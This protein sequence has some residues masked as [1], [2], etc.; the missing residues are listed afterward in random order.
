M[1]QS[2]YLAKDHILEQMQTVAQ[3]GYWYCELESTE[4][5]QKNLDQG[6]FVS[7]TVKRIFDA[8]ND[9]N[10]TLN[11]VKNLLSEAEYAS[12]IKLLTEAVC[13][14][15]K[16]FVVETELT[17]LKQ[18]KI[19]I[20]ITG[21]GEHS[22]GSIRPVFG[23]LQDIS[24][25]KTIEVS[26]IKKSNELEKA[27]TYLDQFVHIASHDLRAPLRGIQLLTSLI[28]E[29]L[30]ETS[31]KKIFENF[32]LL[33]SRVRRMDALLE[34]LLEFNVCAV[35]VGQLSTFD[36]KQAI[37]E[38]F[39]LLCDGESNIR[40]EVPGDF[41]TIRSYHVPFQTVIRNLIQNSMKHCNGTNPL[42]IHAGWRK[43]SQGYEFSIADNGPGIP[44]EYHKKVFE[45][46][47][48]LRPRDEIEGSGMGLAIVQ[49]VL[50]SLG[51]KIFIDPSYKPGSRFVFE[52]PTAIK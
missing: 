23:T 31:D 19:W 45:V 38:S 33:K 2:E 6:I 34:S 26:L 9:Y 20:R 22:T 15:G 7:D 50:E 13:T 16:Q 43:T 1:K 41:P 46:F 17:T 12:A 11:T 8:P 52:W 21:I 3:I 39:E 35:N 25:L 10:V 42:V 27:N 51:G 5:D 18:R 30:P 40:L 36:A 28:E 14:P 48:T 49:K 37:K 47:K 44:A 32:H 4:N 24:A 29:S